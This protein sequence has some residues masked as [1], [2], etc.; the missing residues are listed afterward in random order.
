MI[1]GKHIFLDDDN[2]IVQ[3]QEQYISSISGDSEYIFLLKERSLQQDLKNNWFTK[4][5]DKR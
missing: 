3:I 1:N 5:V 4:H 2:S